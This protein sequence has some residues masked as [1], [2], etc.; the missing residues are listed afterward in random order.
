MREASER[1]GVLPAAEVSFFTAASEVA[2]VELS[3]LLDL[4]GESPAPDFIV[5]L[6]DVAF[7]G[8]CALR[9][10]ESGRFCDI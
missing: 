1:S 10:A 4:A 6:D 8:D 2:A 3:F 9:F 7:G 5:V